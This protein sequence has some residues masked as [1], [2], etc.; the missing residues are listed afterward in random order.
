M[1]RCQGQHNKVTGTGWASEYNF[2]ISQFWRLE[3]QDQT[4]LVSF[5]GLSPG[6]VDD[7][8]LT[9]SPHG[10][11]SVHLCPSLLF[12]QGHQ[13]AW[14]GTHPNISLK[15]LTHWTKPWCW[16]RLKAK[17]ES[18]RGCD[19][20]IASPIQWTWTWAN[21][22]RWWG[23]GRPG[24]LQS[25]GSHRVGQDWAHTHN[26]WMT[27]VELWRVLVIQYLQEH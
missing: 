5:R 12:S 7:H 3:V 2:D 25:M 14:I 6:C 27:V 16:E 23:T 21:S 22:G 19:V 8:L 11:P 13:S 1:W 17:E 18:G 26:C 24:L 15:E 10:H 20:W 4:E 9:V